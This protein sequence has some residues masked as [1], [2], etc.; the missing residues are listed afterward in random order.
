M[1]SESV[2]CCDVLDSLEAFLRKYLVFHDQR[3][4]TWVASW[5]LGTWLHRAFPVFPYLSVRSASKR[6]G[7]S[8]LL[9]LASKLGFNAS[10]VLTRPTE[11][12]LFRWPART[13]GTQIF[14]EVESL[15]GDAA[16]GTIAVLNA[17]FERDGAVMRIERRGDRFVDVDYE[18][19]S[20]KLLASIRALPDTL[21]DRALPVWMVRRSRE[22]D[23]SRITRGTEVE[24]AQL[25]EDS[26]L[27]SL[28]WFPE[29]AWTYQE[30]LTT[31]Q[32]TSMDDRAVD[33]WAPVLSL[34]V[35]ADLEDGHSRAEEVLAI[36][37]QLAESRTA[38]AESSSTLKLIDALRAISESEGENIAPP[39][40]A[41]ALRERGFEWVKS[42]KALANQLN[43][44][45]LY[46][47]RVRKGFLRVYV[48]Q[49][50]PDVIADLRSR[51]SSGPELELAGPND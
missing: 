18:V 12:Q 42:T 9:R 7:K 47:R 39:R 5:I 21:E 32:A 40:L 11:A 19:F 33:L 26:A 27:A 24:A 2:R 10:P 31:L 46:R 13:A 44:L 22:E 15:H 8:R 23:I 29:I 20:P 45:G 49:L 38:D 37:Q 4:A 1:S 36:A 34:C 17:G 6:C 25:R 35:F 14:D 51:Y 48:Y 28:S 50:A 43:P 3:T 16:D 30:A 41:E